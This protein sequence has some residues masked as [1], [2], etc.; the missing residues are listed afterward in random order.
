ML[1]HVG[2]LRRQVIAMLASEG[3]PH[4]RVRRGIRPHSGR[5]LEPG[6]GLCGQS[7]ILQLEHRLGNSDRAAH[8][9]ECHADRGRGHYGNMERSRSDRP[10]RGAGRF[11]RTGEAMRAVAQAMGRLGARRGGR[12]ECSRVRRRTRL[13]ARHARPYPWYSR[14][15]TAA[16]RSF[17]NRVVVRHRLAQHRTRGIAGFSGHIFFRTKT[18][19]R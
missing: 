18:E 3:H 12:R 5:C 17:R 16:T 11:A 2:M 4:Q 15:T 7:P 6:F 13:R 1:R 10:R 8:D 14:P 9:L 19:H